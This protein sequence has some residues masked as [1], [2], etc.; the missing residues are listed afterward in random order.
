VLLVHGERALLDSWS[1]ITMGL[2]HF[3]T[4]GFISMT[5]I[6]A[7]YR[8]APAELDQPAPGHRLALFAWIGF[9]LG[10]AALC[11]G[12]TQGLVVPV[13]VAIGALF[14]ALA[15]FLLPAIRVI[16]SVRGHPAAGPWRLAIG[17]FFAVSA[18]GVWVAHGHGGM[19]FPGP[20]SLWIQLHLSIALFGWVGAVAT[21]C[22]R[23]RLADCGVDVPQLVPFWST[24]GGGSVLLC[25]LVLAVNY[26]GALDATSETARV[27]GL[28]A[29]APAAFAT[30]I[31]SAKWGFAGLACEPRD[32]IP[33]DEALL[34][35]LAFALGPV[36]LVCAGLAI[37]IDDAMSRVMFGWIAIWGWAG[38]VGLATLFSL[39]PPRMPGGPILGLH[40]LCLALG[41]G[42]TAMRS[43]ALALATGVALIAL[44]AMLIPRRRT[45]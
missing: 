1:P 45:A 19:E 12:L 2:T 3:A 38:T 24:L 8:L 25:M 37:A 5:G 10:V 17:S 28:I 16:R 32:A 21:A 9:T 27:V 31:A 36:T 13:F 26:V 29:A 30:A 22:L 7:F 15:A 11:V 35:R 40:A 33:R 6:G 41:L 44:A 42:A 4:L 43:N 23:A 20:R 18:L 39:A 34:W 14:P